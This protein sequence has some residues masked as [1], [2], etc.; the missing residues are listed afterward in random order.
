MKVMGM[1]SDVALESTYLGKELGLEASG[2]VVR[3][4]EGADFEVGERVFLYKGGTLR[5]HVTVD[6]RFAARVPETLDACEAAT[7]FVFLTSWYS[8]V[9]RANLRAGERVLIHSAAG[10]VGLS[11]VQIAQH[12]GAEVFATAGTPEKREYLRSLGVEHVWNSRTLDWERKVLAATNGEGVDVVLN[13]LAGPAIEAGLNCLGP[14][15]RF[16]ELG[17]KDIASDRS[18]GMLPFNRNLSLLAVDLDRMA[19]ERPSF[20]APLA[21]E[22]AQAFDSG[23]LQPIRNDVF[24]PDAVV[25]AFRAL[26]SGDQIGK[27]VLDLRDA[28]VDAIE[29]PERRFEARADAA[30]LVTGGLAGFGLST[31]EWL[32]QSGAKSLYL[33]SRR[34]TAPAES[35]ETL[36]RIEA[37]GAKV[38]E[39]ALDVTDTASI[40]NAFAKIDAAGLPLAGV[41]HAAAVI[42]DAL[43]A[44]LT[45]ENLERTMS[46]KAVG[47][48]LL[49]A[50][51]AERDDVDQFVLFSSISATVGNPGQA[52]YAAANAYL[53]GLA[54][55]RI[56]QGL[57][58]TVVGW[59]AIG[60]A[61]VVARDASLAE[62]LRLLGI[63]TLDAPR[64]LDALSTV[65][66]PQL[67][68][69][70]IVDI[71]WNTWSSAMSATPW[72]RL[73]HLLETTDN[74]D[75][76][77]NTDLLATLV[78]TAAE[79]FGTSAD[80]LDVT[81]PL[82]DMGLDSLM[83]VELQTMIAR[84][85]GVELSVMEL[86]AGLGLEALSV[87]LASRMDKGDSTVQQVAHESSTSFD[88][89]QKFLE[90][91]LV[92]P[93]YFALSEMEVDGELVL[94]RATPDE[95][96]GAECGPVTSAEAGRHL[97]ILG[98]CAASIHDNARPGRHV[99]PVK[100]AV[101]RMNT[102]LPADLTLEDATRLSARCLSY[103][104]TV[105]RSRGYMSTNNGQLL[106]TLDCDYHV[107]EEAHFRRIMSAHAR[108]TGEHVVEGSPYESLVVPSDGFVAGAQYILEFEVTPDMCLGHF[109]GVPTLPVS[110]MGRF[111]MQAVER[112]IGGRPEPRVSEAIIDTYRFI[113][114]GE[115]VRFVASAMGERYRCDVMA[116]STLA[117]RFDLDLREQQQALR[118]SGAYA[119][120]TWL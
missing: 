21:A 56:A 59:G 61:G 89:T 86:L 81:R 93:P 11:A 13:A 18:L 66:E 77:A 79:I 38:H 5:S 117:A 82:R 68:Y 70:G 43:V 65:L 23:A 87:K 30:Y 19:E 110:I 64:A 25:A 92:H 34:G 107:I 12:L 54:D 32:A 112:A 27:V 109:P 4:G 58:A 2:R 9:T 28:R 62:H 15:G 85:L 46:A 91:I 41:F 73:E 95:V 106:A 115:T 71:D 120:A 97:A 36:A 1:L 80:K 39:L 108:P 60:G 50:A 96:E 33:G 105:A 26:A 51:T 67:G 90:R 48:S 3:V 74:A 76:D 88:T 8:L 118:R 119:A 78:A 72:H 52:A 63:H 49:H 101:L 45:I 16:V 111:V 37:L 100:R 44:E 55:A 40:A 10:G 99:Y 47:A 24:G 35:A 29:P 31:A 14:G 113:H 114:C 102:E 53:E 22:V 17:K 20:F 75:A 116:G 83:A 84:R 57:P 103:S 7:I 94:A 69:I 6:A 42:D 98:S 104:P